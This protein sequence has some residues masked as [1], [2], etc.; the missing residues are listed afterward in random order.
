MHILLTVYSTVKQEVNGGAEYMET[1]L[2]HLGP[3]HPTTQSRD[4]GFAPSFFIFSLS[5]V[6]S[7]GVVHTLLTACSQ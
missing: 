5:W 3:R 6:K 4:M 2:Q 1:E 7:I